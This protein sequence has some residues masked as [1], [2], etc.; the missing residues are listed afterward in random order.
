MV[1]RD[2]MINGQDER[3]ARMARLCRDHRFRGAS[4]EELCTAAERT[5]IGRF[6]ESGRQIRLHIVKGQLSDEVIGEISDM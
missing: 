4:I 5:Y 2:E 1:A 3:V 6:W